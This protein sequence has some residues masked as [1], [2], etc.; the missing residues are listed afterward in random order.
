VTVHLASVGYS[1]HHARHPSLA[2][3]ELRMASDPRF[4]IHVSRG[5]MAK[6]A[7]ASA[8]DLEPIDRLEEK[9]GMLVGMITQLRA[10][11]AKSH[12]ANARLTAEIEQLR[13]RLADAEQVNV[14]L[15]ALRDERDVIRSRVSEMLQQLEAI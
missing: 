15:A 12:D 14:E 2:V 9:I 7:L 1:W 13:A 3:D 8:V 10:E 11:Q 5:A 4:D 6:Q